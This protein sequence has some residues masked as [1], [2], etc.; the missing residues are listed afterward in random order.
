MCGRVTQE[1][2]WAK[3]LTD[4]VN[5]HSYWTATSNSNIGTGLSNQASAQGP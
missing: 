5:G 2:I 3:A 4:V 1:P